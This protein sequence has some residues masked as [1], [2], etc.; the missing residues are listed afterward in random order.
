MAASIT[1]LVV[2]LLMA[3]GVAE[4]PRSEAIVFDESLEA[5]TL[6]AETTT[7]D[8]EDAIDALMKELSKRITPFA[9]SLLS[10]D[11]VT[12]DCSGAILQ[13]LIGLRTKMPWALRMVD[14][15]GRPSAGLLFGTTGSYGD[16]DEC[17]SVRHGSAT[18]GFAGKYCTLFYSLPA[19]YVRKTTL[20]MQKQ[21]YYQGR[22]APDYFKPDVESYYKGLRLG[23]CVPSVCSVKDVERLIGLVLGGFGFKYNV[24]GCDYEDNP[25]RNWNP[26]R[27]AMM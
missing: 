20:S 10:A 5:T 9:A 6:S 25:D 13:L 15:T 24:T 3:F 2:F 12:Q 18:G 1:V 11:N 19:E 21:G 27:I 23:L 16:Y 17:L 14:A 22:R 4:S 7:R 26:I 8:F